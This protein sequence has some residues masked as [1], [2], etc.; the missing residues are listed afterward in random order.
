VLAARRLC[1]QK[2]FQLHGQALAQQSKRI[3][4]TAGTEPS[5]GVHVTHEIDSESLAVDAVSL[6]DLFGG[7]LHGRRVLL[8]LDLQGYELFALRGAQSILPF[9]GIVLLP[10][11]RA[12]DFRLDELPKRA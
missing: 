3:L 7:R 9:R 8:K 11:L 4:M 6:D 12:T 5:T 2:G 1:E 10:S